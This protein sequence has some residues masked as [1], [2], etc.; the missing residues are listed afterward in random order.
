MKDFKTKRKYQLKH[1]LIECKCKNIITP[2]AEECV[3]RIKFE[4][5]IT[6]SAKA[7]VNRMESVRISTPHQ[8]R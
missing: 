4:N 1:E 8:L 2:S 5:I 3:N 6:P 7:C